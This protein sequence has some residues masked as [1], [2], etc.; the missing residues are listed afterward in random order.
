MSNGEVEGNADVKLYGIMLDDEYDAVAPNYYPV[1]AA[2]ESRANVD[3]EIWIGG[4]PE[5]WPTEAWRAELVGSKT[6]I[7]PISRTTFGGAIYLFRNLG[8]GGV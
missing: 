4:N 3:R 1:R 8:Q 6:L 7:D 5:Y 2:S